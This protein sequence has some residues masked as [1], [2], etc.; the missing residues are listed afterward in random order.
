[1]RVHTPFVLLTAS[2]FCSVAAHAQAPAAS[3]A[4]KQAAEIVTGF[5]RNTFAALRNAKTKADIAK[6]VD[7]LEAPDWVSIDPRGYTVLTRDEAQRQLERFLSVEPAQRPAN[8]IEVL[9]VDAE[10]W[11][12]TAVGLV[13]SGVQG[14]AAMPAF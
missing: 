2:V 5:Y 10:P 6:M 3:V 4:E 13:H 8:N 12:I 9:W 11:R 1:M 14:S 7:D